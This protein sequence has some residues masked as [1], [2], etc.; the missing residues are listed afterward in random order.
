MQ[1]RQL[2]VCHASLSACVYNYVCIA[3]NIISITTQGI[4]SGENSTDSQI[5]SSAFLYAT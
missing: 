4:S 2:H 5:Q 1:A 3:N